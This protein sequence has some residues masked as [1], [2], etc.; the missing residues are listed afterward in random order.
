MKK[1]S[2]LYA[3]FLPDKYTCTICHITSYKIYFFS[4][5]SGS[6]TSYDLNTSINYLPNAPVSSG[7]SSN[8]FCWETARL[9]LIYTSVF[10][11]HKNRQAGSV[12]TFSLPDTTPGSIFLRTIEYSLDKC[13]M[14]FVCAC[15][16]KKYIKV[17]LNLSDHPK[18]G[19]LSSKNTS[20]YRL[21]IDNRFFTKFSGSYIL[22][23]CILSY[24]K[25]FV[26]FA[27]T[28]NTKSSGLRTHKVKYTKSPIRPNTTEMFYDQMPE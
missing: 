13:E 20:M 25:H 18:F 14:L 4:A 28:K 23:I 26:Y 5:N 22:C 19:E 2:L 8:K 27:S 12:D 3:L 16:C 10:G 11:S 1:R 15:I 17:F 24:F 9:V 6:F 7:L 21:N